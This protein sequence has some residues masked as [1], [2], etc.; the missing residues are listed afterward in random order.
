MSEIEMYSLSGSL[1]SNL[2]IC[3]EM[4]IIIMSLMSGKIDIFRHIDSGGPPRV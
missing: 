4:F 3:R 1:A 2:T